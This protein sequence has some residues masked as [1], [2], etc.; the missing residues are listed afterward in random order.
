MGVVMVA[1]VISGAMAEHVGWRSFWWLNTALLSLS[2][3]LVIF[4]FPETKWHRVY[5]S[6][7]STGAL[8][9]EP[10]EKSTTVD[11]SQSDAAGLD[12]PTPPAKESQVGKGKPSKEQ[13]KPYSTNPRPARSLALALWV[14]CK[15]FAFP[16]VVFAGFVVSWSCS[17]FLM[18]NLIQSQAFGAAPYN[19]SSQSI[20]E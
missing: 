19:W 10:T 1:P 4:M 6:D 2:T 18:T 20:G 14:P 12:V 3:V 5:P 11:D 7:N 16:I 9:N 15:L 13:W 17:S 8:F